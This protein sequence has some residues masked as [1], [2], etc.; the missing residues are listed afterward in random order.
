MK[1]TLPED[2]PSQTT[3]AMPFLPAVPPGL[4]VG[5]QLFIVGPLTLACSAAPEE[6]L[7]EA[8]TQL[9]RYCNVAFPHL[10]RRH[11][12]KQLPNPLRPERSCLSPLN[13]RRRSAVGEGRR[14]T[15]PF[16][17]GFGLDVGRVPESNGTD[18]ESGVPYKRPPGSPESWGA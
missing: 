3:S 5:D 12:A 10:A 18:P 4:S 8:L 13:D 9:T 11:A 2:A 17:G 7:R 16:S 1:F 15:P 14:E 6:E